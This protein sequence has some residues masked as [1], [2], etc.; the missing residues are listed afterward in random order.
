MNT[1]R[2][3]FRLALVLLILASGGSALA[4]VPLDEAPLSPA[5]PD[6]EIEL[7]P[8]A[9]G[10]LLL[11]DHAAGEIRVVDPDTAAYTR[12]YALGSPSDAHADAAGNLW[13]AD[14]ANQLVKIDVAAKTQTRWS[15]GE[16]GSVN[17][18]G[19]DLDGEG[20][21]WVVDW[22]SSTGFLYRLDPSTT[23]LC[24]YGIPGGTVSTYVLYD[25]PYVWWLNW[26]A[27]RLARLDPTTA[28]AVL[29]TWN[30]GYNA[31]FG[32]ALVADVAGRLWWGDPN[33]HALL[34]FDPL[35]EELASYSPP[36][37]TGPE[38][39]FLKDGKVWYTEGSTGT[40]GWMDPALASGQTAAL[41]RETQELAP[42]CSNLGPG[43][44]F[45]VSSDVG[46]I[47]FA[48]NNMDLLIDNGAWRIYQLP[49]GASPYA[50]AHSSGRWWLSDIGRRML[51][52]IQP[53]GNA[54]FLPFVTR[55]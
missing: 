13:W 31:S 23:T 55:Q 45:Q 35:T 17:L 14:E 15:L 29:D 54:V 18:W 20:N 44:T 10:Q 43:T 21:V 51:L 3:V 42:E 6:I 47:S 34:R 33:A 2:S 50:L 11:S 41:T 30:L 53:R 22:F 46:S 9:A 7:N 32:R 36:V 8:T 40:F 28:P 24:R 52:R 27:N 26:S 38:H 25:A 48:Q 39:V 37:G 5:T 49:S 1:K 4:A 16:P 12:Y 19:V